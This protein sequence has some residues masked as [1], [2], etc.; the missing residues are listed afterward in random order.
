MFDPDKV[1]EFLNNHTESD[2][3]IIEIILKH[4]LYFTTDEVISM[5][6]SAF[7]KFTKM[8]TH[9]NLW[10]ST[11]KIG[12]EHLMLIHLQDILKPIKVITNYQDIDNDYPIVAI[13]DAI[14]S[15]VYM[16]GIIDNLIYSSKCKNKFYCVAG[17]CSNLTPDV[18]TQFNG[19]IIV[20]KCFSDLQAKILFPD[21]HMYDKF[22]CENHEVIPVF[23]EHKIANEFGS[24]QFYHKLI[25]NPI[26]RHR[27]NKI[28][29][30]DIDNLIVNI[31]KLDN[32]V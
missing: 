32:N 11:N 28:S 15:S 9:Y 17:I 24:Y 6:R 20:D 7:Q 29:K 31:I 1:V 2:R 27:I 4:T 12:S 13:D 18:V 23:F 8:V 22:G 21:T 10:I 14:Y 3:Q 30:Q 25:K 19:T 16:C 5:V 26:D